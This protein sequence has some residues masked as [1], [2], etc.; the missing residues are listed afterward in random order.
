MTLNRV[1]GEIEQN[2]ITKSETNTYL[3]FKHNLLLIDISVETSTMS[4][5]ELIEYSCKKGSLKSTRCDNDFNTYCFRQFLQY[6][7]VRLISPFLNQKE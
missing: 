7:P 3:F 5:T 1:M 6:H 2:G 4:E